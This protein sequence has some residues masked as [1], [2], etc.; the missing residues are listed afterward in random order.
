MKKN[1]TKFSSSCFRR[2]TFLQNK[3]YLLNYKSTKIDA[4]T[5]VQPKYTNLLP[6]AS[7]ETDS[8]SCHIQLVFKVSQDFIF[9]K[10]K[11]RLL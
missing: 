5:L 1:Y 2:A 10:S 11:G 4:T 7:D 8:S 9:V 6:H 3:Q